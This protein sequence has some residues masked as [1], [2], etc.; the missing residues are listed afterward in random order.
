MR[1]FD[2]LCKEIEKMDSLQTELYIAE[3][4]KEI[5]PVL[6]NTAEDGVSGS[7]IF[8]LFIL[9]AISADG[10][11]S[12]EEYK[13]IQPILQKIFGDTINYDECKKSFKQYKKEH[14]ELTKY[15]VTL[16]NILGLLS[17]E[18]KENIIIVCML[19]CG[20]DKKITVKEKNWIKQ[21]I[22]A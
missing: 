19:V 22:T 16:V 20:I 9:S 3:A 13:L 17:D 5:V 18:L 6:S 8:M 15:A 7:D 1:D 12:E 4:S 21:L 10:R 14:K 11:L 2:Q